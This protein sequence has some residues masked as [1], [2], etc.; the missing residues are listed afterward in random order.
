MFEKWVCLRDASQLEL[1]ADNLIPLNFRARGDLGRGKVKKCE[2]KVKRGRNC[3][4]FREG[5]FS[6]VEKK[7]KS[8]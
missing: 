3:G 2:E 6:F 7:E 8:L 1:S 4:D 5:K